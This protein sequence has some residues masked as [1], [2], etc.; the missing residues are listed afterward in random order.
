M[1]ECYHR[2][3]PIVGRDLAKDAGRW[4]TFAPAA[5]GRGFG[6]VQAFVMGVRGTTAGALN[7]FRAHPGVLSAR[8]LRLGQGMADIAA[9]A[10]SQERSVRESRDL[11]AQLQG[12]LISRVV[13]EQAKGVLAERA[14]IDMDAAFARAKR[15]CGPRRRDTL[16]TRRAGPP[17]AMVLSLR[18]DCRRL[19]RSRSHGC[20]FQ[21]RREK[22]WEALRGG[23]CRYEEGD[24]NGLLVSLARGGRMTVSVASIMSGSTGRSVRVVRSARMPSRNIVR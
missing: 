2:G 10:L 22:K 11:S 12:A 7:L 15:V 13:I 23:P 21:G 17:P 5:V 14:Q 3:Q 1:F 6:S 16:A 4:P 19:T 9:V 8:D 18:S 20:S 24:V